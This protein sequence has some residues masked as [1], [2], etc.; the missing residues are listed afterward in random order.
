MEDEMVNIWEV[1]VDVSYPGDDGSPLRVFRFASLDSA[2]KFR[3][4]RVVYGGK[5]TLIRESK[6]PYS[7]VK[8]WEMW[9]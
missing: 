4:G 3:N 1:V 7:A 2:N 8:Y 5:P 9:K 6:A